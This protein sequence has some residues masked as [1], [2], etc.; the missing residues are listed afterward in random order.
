MMGIPIPDDMDGK[1]LPLLKKL[2]ENA[3]SR[4]SEKK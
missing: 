2:P 4:V 1:P 3:S